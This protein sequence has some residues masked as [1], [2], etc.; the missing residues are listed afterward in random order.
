MPALK[1]PLIQK[2]DRQ[3]EE[4]SLLKHPYY[5][6]WQAGELTLDDLREYAEQYYYF[7]SEFPRFLSAIHSHCP[8]RE[9]RENVLDNLWD[10]EHGPQN[11]RALWLDFCEGI[12]L[13]RDRL[14]FVADMNPPQGQNESTR[15]LLETYEGLYASDDY[16]DGLAA[17]Y[18][19]ELQIPCIAQVKMQSLKE[20]YQ[21]TDPKTLQF[22]VAHQTQDVGHAEKEAQGIVMYISQADCEH[23]EN[24]TREALDAWWKFLD[25]LNKLRTDRNAGIYFDRD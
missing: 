20:H 8:I 18:A 19:Y 12:G 9:I 2:L 4:R 11:H 15:D 13:D 6:A 23:I 21:I 17:L 25:N 22:F 10:E 7:E 14:E 1:H 24:S 3:I 5:Q 16:Q